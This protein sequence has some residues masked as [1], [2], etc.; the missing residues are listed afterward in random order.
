METIALVFFKTLARALLTLKKE[1]WLE[2]RE[3]VLRTSTGLTLPQEKVVGQADSPVVCLTVLTTAKGTEIFHFMLSLMG[4]VKKNNCSRRDGSI[5]S[6]E[7]TLNQLL[8]TEF[9]Q[10]TFREVRRLI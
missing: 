6:R 9:V 5:L 3:E 8:G 2:G 1:K 4:R 7:R 10:N